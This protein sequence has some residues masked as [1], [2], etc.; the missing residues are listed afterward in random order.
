MPTKEPRRP[1]DTPTV[2]IVMAKPRTVTEA[3]ASS[4]GVFLR[5]TGSRTASN[6]R[7]LSYADRYR[8]ATGVMETPAEYLQRAAEDEER[9]SASR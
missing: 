7:P 3:Q 8:A 5:L 1:A 9:R 6:W 2:R 4:P